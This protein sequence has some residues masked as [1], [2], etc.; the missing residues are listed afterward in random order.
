[1]RN[2][3][4]RIPLN[5][6]TIQKLDQL[7]KEIVSKP[8]SKQKKFVDKKF[9][10]ERK[11][12]WFKQEI[13]D[14]LKTMSGSG[15]RCMY[16][17]NSAS[18]DIEHFRPKSLFP[19][20]TFEWNNMLWVCSPCNRK[21]E[22]A[23]PTDRN[24]HPLII[25]PV[26]ENVWEFLYIDQ[27]FGILIPRSDTEIHKVRAEKTI[28]IL[29]LESEERE[30]LRKCRLKAIQKLKEWINCLTEQLESKTK[31]REQIIKE[32][33]EEKNTSFQPD[34]VDY[35]LNGPGQSEKPFVTFF[36]KLK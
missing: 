14:K 13:I 34:V 8:I 3:T 10:Q 7:T 24:G 35:F 22:H 16:C 2:I 11:K 33:E 29:G 12:Q 25:D 17:S 15:N 18:S 6:K 26:S 4:N 32:L 27:K 20:K 30:Y 19:E 9:A 31:S 5:Q 36:K 23:F 21:K 1:M 28:E